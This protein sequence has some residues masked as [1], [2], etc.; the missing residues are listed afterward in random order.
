MK[1]HKV[2]GQRDRRARADSPSGVLAQTRENQEVIRVSIKRWR[3]HNEYGRSVGR[4]LSE[5]ELLDKVERETGASK[6]YIRRLFKQ[7]D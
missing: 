6:N 2:R 5:A 4:G 7:K 1:T 3:G